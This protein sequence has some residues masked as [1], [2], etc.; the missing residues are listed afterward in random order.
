MARYFSTHPPPLCFSFSPLKYFSPILTYLRTGELRIPPT[1]TARDV[2]CEA[3][4]FMIQVSSPPLLFLY[5]LHSLLHLYLDTLNPPFLSH[6][7]PPPPLHH[8]PSSPRLLYR[9][10]SLPLPP[11]DNTITH[12]ICT[13]YHRDAER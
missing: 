3:K 2:L 11:F 10:H 5:H 4:F 9:L 6:L 13:G 1:M 8:L 12:V 7:P